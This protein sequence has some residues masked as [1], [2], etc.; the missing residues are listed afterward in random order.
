MQWPQALRDIIVDCMQQECSFRPT[1]RQVWLVA[2]PAKQHMLSSLLDISDVLWLAPV[3]A[4][5]AC[6]QRPQTQTS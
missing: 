6:M 2:L 1:A 4:P 3:A 5:S